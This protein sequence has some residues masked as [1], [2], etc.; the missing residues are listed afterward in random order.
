MNDA[1]I[2]TALENQLRR[3]MPDLV[4]SPKARSLTWRVLGAVMGLFN[5]SFMAEYFTT[6]RRHIY[7]PVAYV[8]SD[9]GVIAHEGVHARDDRAHPVWFKLTYLF[10][11]CLVPLALLALLA[12][13]WSRAW[14]LW[15]LALPCVVLPSPGRVYWERRA[16]LMSMCLDVVR[17][18]PG[19]IT[20]DPYR[21]WMI[22]TYCGPDYA[23]MSRSRRR[24]ER[25]MD[26]D[27]QRAIAIADGRIRLEP[28]TSTITLVRVADQT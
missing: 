8:S 24:I 21:E 19:Y 14:L 11:Q 26:A 13:P 25:A 1:K 17:Y 22:R 7:T 10:P 16:Y 18:S 28:Y 9:W 20:A 6:I 15:L 4:I 3:E 2:M 5:K 12:I 23:W 27:A